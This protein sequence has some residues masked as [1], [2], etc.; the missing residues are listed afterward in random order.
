MAFLLIYIREA[1]PGSVIALPG[2]DGQKELHILPQTSTLAERLKN[3]RQLISITN[4]SMP[5]VMDDESN[6][7]K[8]AYAAWPDRLYVVGVD[9]KVAYKGRPGPFGFRVPELEEW[10]R[11]NVK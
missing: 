1:H 10:L 4:V 11:V 3:L 2:K 5:A 7:V 6:S 9:G 8:R